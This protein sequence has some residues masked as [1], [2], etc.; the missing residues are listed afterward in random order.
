MDLNNYFTF[1]GVTSRSLSVYISG[2][3][4]YNAPVRVYDM[5]SIPGKNGSLAIDEKR[6]EDIEL[7]YP[8]FIVQNSDTDFEEKVAAI[9]SELLSRTG[10]KVLTDTYHPDEFRL[11]IYKSGLDVTPKVLNRAGSF[12]LTFHCKPQR[13]LLSGREVITMTGDGS[14]ENPTLFEARPLIRITGTGTVTVNGV[15]VTVT[16]SPTTIDCET[17]E[18]YNGQT[19]RNS[20]IT[21][22][23]NEF[24][25]LGQGSNQVSMTLGISE[26]QITPRWWRI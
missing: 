26:V 10:Y 8:A 4:T 22:S 17:M 21:L 6:F 5:R 20:T 14:I 12:N 3:G 18:A 2:E 24:P 23:P 9:R 16:L 1:D 11:A 7:K 13:F 25:V 15:A 19:S